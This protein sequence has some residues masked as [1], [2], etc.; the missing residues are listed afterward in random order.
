MDY[1]DIIEAIY[2]IYM[3][4]YFKTS[5]SIHHPLEYI[6][7]KQS[8]SNFIK[9]PIDTGEYESKICPLG[10]SVS[11]LIAGWILVRKSLMK[12]NTT[13]VLLLNKIIFWTIF[14]FSLIMNLNAF[15]YMIPVFLYELK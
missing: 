10:N 12:Y 1:K 8:I 7:S 4:N 13:K 14:V 3:Y 15:V 11:W 2:V 9:H 6:L 5:I